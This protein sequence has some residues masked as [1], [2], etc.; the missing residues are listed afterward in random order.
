MGIGWYSPRGN[1]EDTH[2]Y[3]LNN[4]S[5]ELLER[6]NNGAYASSV[7]DYHTL[8]ALACRGFHN[9][10]MTGC[11]ALYS[12]EHMDSPVT[13]RPSPRKIG[14]SLGVSLKYSR[15]MQ[16][17]MKTVILCTKERF[18]DSE[19]CVAFHHGL[20][21][22]YLH[23]DGASRNLH[24]RQLEFADWLMKESISYIDLS[25]DAKKLQSFY[26]QCELHIGYRI[27][28]HIFMSSISRPSLLLIEDGR[29]I[30]LQSVIG[31]VNLKAYRKI[32]AGYIATI[33]DK[34]GIGFDKM[35]PQNNFVQDYSNIL[36]Y[37]ILNGVRFG[38]TRESI[39]RHYPVMERF[40][41]SLP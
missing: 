19:L 11:P 10:V 4:L 1:W 23:S 39:R 38:E 35:T 34:I 40:L 37:E 25:G 12:H 9:F 16:Q 33:L 20:S 21:E 26:A 36:N 2:D 41:R 8:N 29:G 30:A 13:I 18:P 24:K 6:I 27:H 17:Q 15:R 3:P 22:A 31:G 5:M 28:A 32:N 7:R 14:F